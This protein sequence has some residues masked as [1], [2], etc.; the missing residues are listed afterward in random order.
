MNNNIVI[1]LLVLLDTVYNNNNPISLLVRMP[2][3]PTGRV[4]RTP[5]SYTQW[6][7]VTLG[8]ISQVM[9]M[10]RGKKPG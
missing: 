8:W 4:A 5:S 1:M 9:A 3:R 6:W 7:A 2:R 10:L